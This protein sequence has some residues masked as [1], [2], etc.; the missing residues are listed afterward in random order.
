MFRISKG[1]PAYHL[2]SVSKSRLPVF[3]KAAVKNIACSALDEVRRSAGF[4][5]LA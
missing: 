5:L 4:R 3:R 1:S 2:T